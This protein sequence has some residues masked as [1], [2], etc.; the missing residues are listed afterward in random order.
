MLGQTGQAIKWDGL[1]AKCG[2]T[3]KDLGAW[4]EPPNEICIKYACGK[5]SDA[6]CEADHGEH[7][8]LP[9]LWVRDLVTTLREGVE[10]M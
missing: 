1:A 5:C 4:Y 9:C 3:V 10:N 6:A 8:E 7:W 2:S